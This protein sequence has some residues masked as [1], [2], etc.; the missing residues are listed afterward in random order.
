MRLWLV[1]G[2]VG[3]LLRNFSPAF[4]LPLALAAFDRDWDLAV[5]FGIT[6]ALAFVAGSLASIRM[7]KAATFQRSEAMAVVSFTWLTIAVFSAVPY[8]IEGLHPVDALFESMSGLT[9]TGATILTD[10]GAHGRAFFL[11]RAMTQ[12][13]GGLGVI[14]LFVVVLPRLGIAG[15][16]LFFAEASGAPS[17]GVAPQFRKSAGRLWLV[18]SIMTVL[19]TLALLACGFSPFDSICHALTTMAAGGFSPNGESI[20]GY[21]NPAAEWVIT[22]FMLMAGASFALQYKVY[23]TRNLLGFWRDTE[24][25]F[26][27]FV[28]VAIG[29]AVACVLAGGIPGEKELRLGLFQS[30]SLISSTGFASADYELWSDSLKALLLVVMMVGGCAGSAAGGPKAVRILLVARHVRREITRVLHP[31]AVLP[32]KHQGNAVSRDI[33]RSVFTLVVLYFVGYVAVG[34]VLVMMGSDIVLGFSAALACFGNIGPGFGPAGP[35]GNFAGFSIPAKLLLTVS[36]WLGR[37]E[38]VTVLALLH[39][40]VWIGLRLKPRVRPA[41]KLR[42]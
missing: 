41:R 15:R 29:V 23:S 5:T 28:T 2:L 37:L 33:M 34:L 26:Y 3:Q 14:A 10:F 36:M 9:T 13:F 8:V 35:M 30:A 11:W 24:F 19:L 40:D 4:L 32:L 18:Y 16:Q 39:P 7:E 21:A 25:R 27:F 1:F 42:R 31:R 22:P 6:S 17:E 20:M 12:W 38:I